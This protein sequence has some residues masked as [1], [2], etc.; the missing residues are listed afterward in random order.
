MDEHIY[1]PAVFLVEGDLRGLRNRLRKGQVIDARIVLC[2][3]DHKYL[4][5][6]YG[7]NL[8]MESRLSFNRFDEVRVQVNRV[9]PKLELSLRRKTE[10][11]TEAGLSANSGGMDIVV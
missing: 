4:L 2:L 3:S 6:I 7:Y 8:V 5:R 9:W 10:K 11:D 1:E